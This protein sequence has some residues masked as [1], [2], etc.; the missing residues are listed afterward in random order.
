[1]NQAGVYLV[2]KVLEDLVVTVQ[3]ARFYVP[4]PQ[5]LNVANLNHKCAWH[6]VTIRRKLKLELMRETR[7]ANFTTS[8]LHFESDLVFPTASISFSIGLVTITF[9]CQLCRGRISGS[10]YLRLT[11]HLRVG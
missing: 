3:G 6:G 8:C 10:V 7:S 1:M 5:V 2:I 11:V 4:N 9:H